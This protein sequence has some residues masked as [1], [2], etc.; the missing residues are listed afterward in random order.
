MSKQGSSSR[1]V[2]FEQAEKDDLLGVVL[3]RG[4]PYQ[5]LTKDQIIAWL[6]TALGN[7]VDAAID[8][9][10]AF[11]P[12]FTESGV[13]NGRFCFPVPTES[14]SAGSPDCWTLWR[15]RTDRVAHEVSVGLPD[16]YP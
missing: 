2:T 8:S 6:R 3:V 1:F 14:P 12:R 5:I 7:Q 11:I 13:R 15:D 16:W 10:A 9:D 4:N